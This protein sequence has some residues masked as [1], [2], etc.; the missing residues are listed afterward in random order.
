MAFAKGNEKEIAMVRMTFTA[1][2]QQIIVL[3]INID[4]VCVVRPSL[5]V[6]CE[7]MHL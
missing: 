7:N 5:H 4:C 3:A 6:R 1:L 2:Q